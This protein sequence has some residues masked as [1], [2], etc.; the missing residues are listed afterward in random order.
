MGNTKVVGV[1]ERSSALPELH[2]LSSPELGHA[3]FHP[4]T[5]TLFRVNQAV[6]EAG[7]L[8]LSRTHQSKIPSPVTEGIL[9]WLLGVALL[10]AHQK[11]G[12]S[13]SVSRTERDG[14]ST[15][16]STYRS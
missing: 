4:P 7:L 6:A 14:A 16:Q 8:A 1:S 5:L 15:D 10:G 11:G 13:S 9:L 2:V 3:V 12:G